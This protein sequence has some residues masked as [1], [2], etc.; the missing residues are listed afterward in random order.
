M[1]NMHCNP[2]FSKKIADECTS[3]R[4]SVSSKIIQG[5]GYQTTW[6]RSTHGELEKSFLLIPLKLGLLVSGNA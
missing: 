6:P 4:I 5:D 3:W 1:I 2:G